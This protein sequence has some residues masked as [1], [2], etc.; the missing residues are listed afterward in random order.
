ME[1]RAWF[2]FTPQ[3]DWSRS[4]TRRAQDILARAVSRV[5]RAF[6]VATNA[7]IAT[8]VIDRSGSASDVWRR[9][10]DAAAAGGRLI[11]LLER[12]FELK[13]SDAFHKEMRKTFGS[14]ERD[15]NAQV[16]ALVYGGGVAMSSGPETTESCSADVEPLAESQVIRLHVGGNDNVWLAEGT[17]ADL[18]LPD[19]LRKKTLHAFRELVGCDRLLP[20]QYA[21]IGEHLLQA[22]RSVRGPLFSRLDNPVPRNRLELCIDGDDLDGLSALPWE[23]LA[24]PAESNGQVRFVMQDRNTVLTRCSSGPTET[25]HLPRSLNPLTID[26]LLHDQDAESP[27]RDAFDTL[28]KELNN[29]L[30]ERGALDVGYPATHRL[31][32]DRV[33]DVLFIQCLPP[34][35]LDGGKEK[36]LVT[37]SQR[38]RTTVTPEKLAEYV[39]KSNAALLIIEPVQESADKQPSDAYAWLNKFAWQ[40]LDLGAVPAIIVFRFRQHV[41]DLEEFFRA[42]LNNLKRYGDVD[43][44]VADARAEV[45][46]Q[47]VWSEARFG[48]RASAGMEFLSRGKVF[49]YEANAGTREPGATRNEHAHSA[50]GAPQSLWEVQSD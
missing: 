4:D 6:Q 46:E 27:I 41:A 23:L 43:H 28:K 11:V 13:N 42:L 20:D 15:Y 50:S 10:L 33:A 26:A 30:K 14:R 47:G 9:L 5:E 17:M 48:L 39:R 45:L 36:V 25:I 40:L 29:E 32:G 2:E 18:T 31:L 21:L 44:A 19:H 12:F 35:T 3:L 49:L 38:T 1:D 22:L 7:G 37:L 24:A 8:Q 16:E 34:Q